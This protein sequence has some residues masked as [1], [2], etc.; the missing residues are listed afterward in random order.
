MSM[1]LSLTQLRYF[2]AVADCLS[3]TEAARRLHISQPP[4][5][6]SRWRSWRRRWGS[7]SSGGSTGG[8]P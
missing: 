3:Y 5:D 6:A 4:L 8:S 1:N 7:C 2:L